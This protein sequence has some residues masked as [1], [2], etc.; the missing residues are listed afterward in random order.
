MIKNNNCQQQILLISLEI[1]I[2]IIVVLIRLEI[3]QYSLNKLLML[4]SNKIIIIMLIACKLN[5]RL[6]VL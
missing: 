5:L 6:M 2:Y 4:F 3:Y 1:Y